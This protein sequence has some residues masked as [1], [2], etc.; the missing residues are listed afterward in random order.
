M[1]GVVPSEG[2][3]H[4]ASGRR[5]FEP[6]QSGSAFTGAY[7]RRIRGTPRDRLGRGSRNVR[8]AAAAADS[9]R[10]GERTSTHVCVGSASAGGTPF[11]PCAAHQYAYCVYACGAPHARR[12]TPD[13]TAPGASAAFVRSCAESRFTPSH[14]R[15]ARPWLCARFASYP[16]TAARGA[17][18]VR[19]D[20]GRARAAIQRARLSRDSRR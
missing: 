9:A 17:R 4:E 14:T 18:T 19:I 1:G 10:R 12:S 7:A 15:D 20:L 5:D 3:I 6:R 16:A 11:A 8:D 2:L 13:S